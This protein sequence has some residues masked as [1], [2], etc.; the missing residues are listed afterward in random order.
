M[1]D[2]QTYKVPQALKDGYLRQSDYTRKTQD[3]PRCKRTRKRPSA[4]SLDGAGW[5]ETRE[6]Q[7]RLTQIESEL[8]RLKSVDWTQYDTDT[9]IKTRTYMDQ[10]RTR[11]VICKRPFRKADQDRQQA[12]QLRSEAARNAYEFI[13]RHVKDWTPDSATE[14]EVTSYAQNYGVARKFWLK[15]P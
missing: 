14:R 5:E 8:K 13:N 11:R 10:L 15:S 1:E 12:A 9:L 6:E 7:Q 2:G 4:A 3:S